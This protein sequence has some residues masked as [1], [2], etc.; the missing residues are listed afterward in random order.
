VAFAAS[1]IGALRRFLPDF[2]REHP[3]MD[4]A[5]HRAIW[6]LTLCRTPTM[7]GHAHACAKCGTTH[8]A[9]HSCNHRSCPQCGQQDTADWVERELQ[10]RVGAP[11][12]MVTFTLPEELR[13][14]FF[15]PSAKA[16]YE[17]FFAAASTA[18][19]STLANPRWVGAARCGF[20][21]ILHT[22]NRRLLFHPHI[23]TIV[24]GAFT[25]AQQRVFCVKHPKFLVP[26]PVLRKAFR[27]CFQRQL[28]ALRALPEHQSLPTPDPSVWS[29]DWGVHIQ[30]F[31]DG[32]H[33]IQYLGTYVCRTAIADARILKVNDSTVTFSWKDRRNG[34]AKC[35]DTISGVEFT[36]RYLRHVLPSG[37][38]AIRRYGY[39]HPSAKVLRQRVAF[40]TGVNLVLGPVDPPP[41]RPGFV[42]SH[43]GQ[44]LIPV[45]RLLAAWKTGKDPPALTP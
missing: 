29:K 23:H 9:F 24:P 34:D 1:V 11:Y 10:K 12:F 3:V 2:L 7:G 33:I 14:L 15:T 28:D 31:G 6:A 5:R 45:E 38:R 20:T 8:F 35:Q 17:A 21:M 43:C 16:V 41:E 37:L 30:P 42:C 4:R 36:R 19:S 13:A 22:W 39:C 44:K 27:A 32:K 40:H 25:D 18:L 26:Q